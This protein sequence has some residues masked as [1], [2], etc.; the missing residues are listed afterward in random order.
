MNDT[1]EIPSPTSPQD[2][3]SHD[4][5]S[6]PEPN[7]SD[8]GPVDPSDVSL[9]TTGLLTAIRAAIAPGAS[10][11]A[12]ASGVT[13]CRAILSVLEAKP[14]QALV[15]TALPA[16]SPASSLLAMIKQ[17]G[18]LNQ[19]AAMSREQLLD[20]VRQA[21]GALPAKPS[22]PTTAGPRFHLIQIPQVRRPGGG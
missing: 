15:A 8:T 17:P 11:E 6:A 18:F 21:T 4:S 1:P 20:L 9:S 19:L 10:T 16:A 13:A 7:P 5:D 14:G 3:D 22:S 12:R 2:T